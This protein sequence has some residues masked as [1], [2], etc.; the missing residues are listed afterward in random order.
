MRKTR[1]LLP[2]VLCAFAGGCAGGTVDQAP[3]ADDAPTGEVAGA[4]DLSNYKNAGEV[5]CDIM[6]NLP[7]GNIAGVGIN[8]PTCSFTNFDN[9]YYLGSYYHQLLLGG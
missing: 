5:I 8:K 1:P 7:G 3:A 6:N 4:I 2:F 9:F